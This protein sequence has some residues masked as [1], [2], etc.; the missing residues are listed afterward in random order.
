[1]FLLIASK[2]SILLLEIHDETKEYNSRAVL[3]QI[4]F[5]EERLHLIVQKQK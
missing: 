1:M 2:C 4:N 5:M 3:R